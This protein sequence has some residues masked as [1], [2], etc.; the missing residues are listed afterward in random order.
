MPQ[1]TLAWKPAACKLPIL[2]IYVISFF[3]SNHTPKKNCA[4]ALFLRLYKLGAKR[5]E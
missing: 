2:P 3:F 5:E 1:M 4:D